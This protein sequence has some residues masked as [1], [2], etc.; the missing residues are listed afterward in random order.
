MTKMFSY[1]A[2]AALLLL[3]GCSGGLDGEYTDDSGM[4]TYAFKS[5]SK[6]EMTVMGITQEMDYKLE[7]GKVKLGAP[8][9][10]LQVISIDKDGCLEVG[11]LGGKVCKKKK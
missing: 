2:I 1:V 5:G 4:V 10:P 7:D 6:V 11:G 9:G 8:G 3:P